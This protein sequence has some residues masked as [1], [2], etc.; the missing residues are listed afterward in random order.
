MQNVADDRYAQP[1]EIPFVV[2]DGIHV[3]HRLGGVFMLAI[4]GVQ[5]R[6]AGAHV[7][8][9]KVSAAAVLVANYEYVDMHRFQVL[10]GI[11]QGFSLDGGRSIDV[12][13]QDVGRQAL[14]GEFEGRARA[15]S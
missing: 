7:L 14:L 4:A 6:D 13:A 3:Q 10:Q 15:R 8:C 12:Q 9:E 11:E 2:P 5:Y 1:G